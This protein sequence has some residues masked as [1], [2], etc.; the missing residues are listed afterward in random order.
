[1][2]LTNFLPNVVSVSSLAIF[3]H[4]L[5]DD[6]Q[7]DSVILYHNRDMNKTNFFEKFNKFSHRN[8]TITL[9]DFQHRFEFVQKYM[10]GTL[11]VHIMYGDN[12]ENIRRMGLV[13][14]HRCLFI[15]DTLCV[16]PKQLKYLL[17]SPSDKCETQMIF[18]ETSWTTNNVISDSEKSIQVFLYNWMQFTWQG[19][20][21]EIF[22]PP[23]SD[24]AHNLQTIVFQRSRKTL[25]MF[26]QRTKL[27]RKSHEMAN[28][29][30]IIPRNR[31]I[32]K[33]NYFSHN[34]NVY[35]V[36]FVHGRNGMR[37]YRL[38]MSEEKI[39]KKLFVS[40]KFIKGNRAV[41]KP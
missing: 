30:R 25:L 36:Q 37:A 38:H 23:P 39:Y 20:I 34:L 5:I 24:R 15:G 28:D 33:A 18:Y 12:R 22:I 19:S 27:W 7:Y 4:R 2:N 17:S 16:F 8:Y 35:V 31:D 40:L 13:I 26:H 11:Q 29:K 14:S 41:F 3:L 6:G 21:S 9:Y 32:C 1:M 10:A